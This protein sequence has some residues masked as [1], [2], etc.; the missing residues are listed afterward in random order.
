MNRDNGL[1]WVSATIQHNMTKEVRYEKQDEEMIVMANNENKNGKVK[2]A[3]GMTIN[4]G[5][6]ESLRVDV[7]V[8]LPTSAETYEV[9]FEDAKAKVSNRLFAEVNEAKRNA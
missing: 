8:E 7:G 4:L 3:L 6:F 2:Y 9:D 5:N 1:V